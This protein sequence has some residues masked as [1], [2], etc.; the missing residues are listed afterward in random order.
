[1]ESKVMLTNVVIAFPKLFTPVA[2]ENFGTDKKRYEAQI[3]MY[4]DAPE[5]EANVAALR[6]AMVNLAKEKW[7][8]KAEAMF[9]NTQDS[10]NTRMLQ[11]DEEGG[12]W[13][14]SAKRKAEDGAPL[15][16]DRTRA[17]LTEAEGKPRSGDVV[18]AQ[19]SIWIYDNASS[20]GFSC[21]L[22]GVQWVKEGDIPIGGTGVATADDF[23]Q[24]E[25]EGE[26]TDYN[27]YF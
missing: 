14:F 9:K 18:N 27:Q 19:V 6:T 8:A 20:K 10:K 7:G 2:N 5:T 23:E 21:T 12:F 4:D 26:T 16:I 3:R 13:K 24:L 11:R 1:M 17:R 22:L 15:V 25:S